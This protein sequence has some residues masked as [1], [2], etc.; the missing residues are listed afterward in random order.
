MERI[1]YRKTLDVHKNGVQFT[2]QGFNTADKMARTIEISL[3]ASGDTIDLPLEQISAVMYV[4][5]PKATEP[6][7]NECTIK[8]NVIVCDVP[9][10][11]EEG[12][13]EMEIKLIETSPTGAKGVL[14]TPKFAI[15]VSESNADDESATQTT[16]YTALEDALAKAKGV[17]DTRIL[18]V[19]IDKDCTFR[20]I[21][22]DGTVYET[23]AL[24]ETLLKGEAILAQSYARG[25]TGTREGEDTDNSMY[26]SKVS[27]NA[28]IQAEDSRVKAEELL[29]ETRKHGVYTAFSL[30][31]ETGELKYI[32]PL[33]SFEINETTGELDATGETYTPEETVEQ[34][35]TEWLESKAGEISR[36]SEDLKA[37]EDANEEFFDKAYP[38]GSIYISNAN[39]NPS[40]KFGGAWQLKDKEFSNSYLYLD[41]DGGTVHLTSNVG[42]IDSFVAYRDT[43][44]IRI[45][46]NLRI[47]EYTMGGDYLM[48][49]N[50]SDLGCSEDLHLN[51]IMNPV[52]IMSAEKNDWLIWDMSSNGE[53]RFVK[54]LN[55]NS[56]PVGST[57]YFDID[58]PV[59]QDNML[60][61]AC[62]KFYWLR[63][64]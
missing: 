42:T 57:I 23:T 8:H 6:S 2:L 48:K 35:V 3:M 24:N 52:L 56:L 11:V 36:I 21:Y 46:V 45:K 47:T 55:E 43:W 53:I 18:R 28:S 31:F 51:G 27:N 20:V 37:L 10:I 29:M 63:T 12:I 14:G 5:T 34:V 17:Y 32:S 38:V 30:D 15:E 62:N 33:Y 50:L 9:K 7:I 26:Y 60:D 54:M 58:L 40:A 22:A 64:S 25:G 59:Y 61:S 1:V 44:H 4:T 39:E 16:T 41:E 19:E 49:L 13:T